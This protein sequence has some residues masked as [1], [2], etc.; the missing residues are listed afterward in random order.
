MSIDRLQDRIRKLKNPTAVDF[1][2]LPEQI[3]AHIRAGAEESAAYTRFCR[4]L[5][6]GLKG[7]V[8]AVRFSFGHLALMGEGGLAALSEL[9]RQAQEL[10][11]YV[12]LDSSEILTPWSADRAAAAFFGTDGQYPCD[13]LIV[14]PY[15]GSDAIKPFIPYCKDGEKDLFFAVRTPN[16]SAPELQDLLTGG[17][18]VHTAAADLVSRFGDPIVGKFGYSRIG[19]LVSAGSDS[20]LANL[21]KKYQ[22][23][24]LF[25]D[26]YDYPSGNAKNSSLA[27]D[28]LGRGAIVCAGPSIT[29]AWYSAETDGTDFVEQ[30]VRAADRMKKNISRYITVL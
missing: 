13:G 8:P 7:I 9:L 10:G 23:M 26:G 11:Y 3:P 29:A 1:S 30:A 28:R 12:V 15:I 19:A 27:F 6:V 25:V 14:S 16:K 17:R 5:M 24:F 4:E 2:I 18:L 20:S 21:R 22:R